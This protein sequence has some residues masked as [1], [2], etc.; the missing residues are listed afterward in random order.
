MKL[1]LAALAIVAGFTVIE[2][3]PASAR[4]YPYCLVSRGTGSPGDC[5]YRS[6]RECMATASGRVASCHINPRVAFGR[7]YRGYR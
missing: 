5:Q 1:M 2:T 6:Y 7:Q 3:T 4:D